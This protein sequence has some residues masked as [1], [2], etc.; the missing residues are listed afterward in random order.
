MNPNLITLSHATYAA[1]PSGATPAATYSFF[2]KDYKPPAEPR[3][4]DKDVVINQNGK[5]KYIYDN[6]P[7]FK[8]WAP[9]SVVCEEIHRT[10]LGFT[11]AQQYAHLRELWE[12]RG[13]LG[14]STPDGAHTVAWSSDLERNF[15]VF[16]KLAGA[17]IIDYE[18]VIQ[19]EEAQ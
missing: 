12:Y 18:V 16:P 1:G 13:V 8:Q 7:G 5:F 6:G 19:F 9:F 15:R 11:A 17:S 4:V 3:A 10:L 14:M 2:T